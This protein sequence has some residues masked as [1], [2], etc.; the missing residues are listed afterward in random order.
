MNILIIGLGSIGIRH[1]INF[2]AL[3][4]TANFFALRHCES[5]QIKS[6]PGFDQAIPDYQT[7]TS[8]QAAKDLDP[9]LIVIANP[10][11]LHAETALFFHKETSAVILLEKPCATN[12]D[13]LTLLIKLRILTEF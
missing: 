2:H 1:L 10:S 7:I 11:A 8:L 13:Q 4:P 3:N 12:L 5:E 6:H 9:A